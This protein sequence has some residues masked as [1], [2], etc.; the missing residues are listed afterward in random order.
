MLLHLNIYDQIPCRPPSTS[1][2]P[3]PREVDAASIVH[4]GR[5]LYED[6]FLLGPLALPGA[7]PAKLQVNLSP[8]LATRAY[9]GKGRW[10]KANLHL[11][12]P[13][14]LI[15]KFLRTCGVNPLPRAFGAGDFPFCTN[16]LYSSSDSLLEFDL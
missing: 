2:L 16:L 8:S 1:S 6:D 11:A 10:G 14:A 7:E 5:D 4:P 13:T 12:G 9:M 15:T 3:H